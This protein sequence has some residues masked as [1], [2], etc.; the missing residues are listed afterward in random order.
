MSQCSTRRNTNM[1]SFF[2]V[3]TRQVRA[4]CTAVF[5]EASRGRYR[6]ISRPRAL[7]HRRWRLCTAAGRRPQRGPTRAGRFVAECRTTVVSTYRG[8]DRIRVSTRGMCT[9]IL[10]MRLFVFGWGPCT[11]E[12]KTSSLPLMKHIVSSPPSRP[13]CPRARK[14]TS[15]QRVQCRPITALLSGVICTVAV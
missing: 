10:C 6:A 14:S 5:N 9:V 12:F 3:R 8:L 13:V 2:Y 7:S 4:L 1:I 15:W 11:A